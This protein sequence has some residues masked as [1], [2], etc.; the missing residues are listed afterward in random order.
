M[1]VLVA[2][3]SPMPLEAQTEVAR[4]ARVRVDLWPDYDRPEVLVLITAELSAEATLPATIHLRLPTE[5]G[6][7]T[8]VAHINGDGQMFNAPFQTQTGDGATLLTVETTEPMVRVEYY[9][10]Y[11]RVDDTVRLVYTW[12]GG[13]AA[14]ELTILVQEPAQATRFVTEAAFEDI[15]L[16]GDGWRYHQWQVG[17]VERDETHSAT[18]TYDA[19]PPAP[20]ES[21]TTNGSSSPPIGY[22]LTAVCGVL[23]GAGI[24]WFLASRR[25][26]QIRKAVHCS[27]C[28]HKCRPG[29]Q[30]CRKC[31]AR[32]G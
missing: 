11:S 6:D 1:L 15:G 18:V 29:D 24:G 13:I 22:I 14:D 2:M 20:A 12:L 30:F 28:G 25:R 26:V 19:P 8:A 5:V 31:G 3:L 16:S 27:R 32:T 23:I 9:F 10:P 4:L 7:P 21:R 17:A